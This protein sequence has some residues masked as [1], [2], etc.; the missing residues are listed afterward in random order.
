MDQSHYK[1]FGVKPP[2]VTE[3]VVNCIPGT[4]AQSN[5]WSFNHCTEMGFT[6]LDLIPVTSAFSA[7]N[8]S[9]IKLNG[10]ILLDMSG[11]A[12]DSSVCKC[13]CSLA[14]SKADLERDVHLGVIERVPFGDPVSWCHHMVVTRKHNGTPHR[15]VDL[16]P[17][18]KFC[19]RETLAMESPFHLARKVPCNTWKTVTDA[20]RVIIVFLCENVIAV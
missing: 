16:S 5:L 8:K 14:K 13:S 20:W 3:M 1:S 12:P 2:D 7:A 19:K 11:V 9:Q 10:T 18:N 17:L 4:A 15:T 6:N